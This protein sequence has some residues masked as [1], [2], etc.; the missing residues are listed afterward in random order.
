MKVK[1]R[2]WSGSTIKEVS[3]LDDLDKAVREVINEEK[4]RM[5]RWTSTIRR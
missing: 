3:K 1:I 2:V 4:R 5:R